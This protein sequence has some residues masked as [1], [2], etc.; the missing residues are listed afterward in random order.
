MTATT[1]EPPH[2]ETDL[3][4]LCLSTITAQWRPRAEQA[5]GQVPAVRRPACRH[6]ARYRIRYTGVTIGKGMQILYE[7]LPIGRL[8]VKKDDE[9]IVVGT[10]FSSFAY[11]L[12][13][14][15]GLA[16]LRIAIPKSFPETAALA[17]APTLLK[18]RIT[19]IDDDTE[20]QTIERLLHPIIQELKI[21]IDDTTGKLS[22]PRNL[23]KSVFLAMQRIR[24]DLKCM[25]LGFNHSLCIDLNPSLDSL[26]E[27]DLHS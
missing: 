5:A 19:I 26:N 24:R 17:D 3:K 9:T 16:A 20:H 7:P 10:D 23:P 27:R 8:G 6:P 11:M 25:A 21:V 22:K 15:I 2:L 12:E 13:E 4:T 1:I 18:P 14:F